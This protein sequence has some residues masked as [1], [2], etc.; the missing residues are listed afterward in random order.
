MEVHDNPREAMS[1]GANALDLRL[2]HPTL[3]ELLRVRQA[4]SPHP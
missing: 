3:E 2:L 4:V 1:E